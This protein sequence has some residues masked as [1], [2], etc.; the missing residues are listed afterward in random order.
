MES[1]IREEIIQH[2]RDN[3]LF[4]TFQYGFI[5]RR[6][7]TLQLLYV[8]DEWTEILD[9]GGTID[10]VY[11]DFMKDFDKV[12]HARLQKKLESYGIGGNLLKWISSFL[13]GRRQKVC[14]GSA[15]SEWSVV[16]R[17]IPQ[18]SVLGPILFIIYIND[19]PDALKNSSAAIMYADDTK[20]YRRTDITNGQ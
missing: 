2:M 1:L 3:K 8:L 9:S 19:L 14:V 16:T 10:A 17:G 6:S 4:S 18:G 20:V 5:D 11:M 7:T 15:T 12:P 13:T